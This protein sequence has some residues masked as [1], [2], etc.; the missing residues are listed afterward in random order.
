MASPM[1]LCTQYKKKM[2]G[3]DFVLILIF[4]YVI[5]EEARGPH[6]NLVYVSVE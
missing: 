5:E 2:S 3:K 1:H 4:I 6:A